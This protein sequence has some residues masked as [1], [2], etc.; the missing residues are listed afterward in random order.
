VD[1]KVDLL[2]VLRVWVANLKAPAVLL[3]VLQ[4]AVLRV[5]T[6]QAKA[7]WAVLLSLA[8]ADLSVALKA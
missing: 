5:V 8:K 4:W 1:H 6:N 3:A 7:A 2:V